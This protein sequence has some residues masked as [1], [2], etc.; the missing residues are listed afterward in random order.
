VIGCAVEDS[1]R[2]HGRVDVPR[3]VIHL[4]RDNASPA[5][6][7]GRHA[8]IKVRGYNETTGKHYS[9]RIPRALPA[10]NQFLTKV[11]MFQCAECKLYVSWEFGAAVGLPDYKRPP[12]LG[13]TFR[14]ALSLG[15][16]LEERDRY[17]LDEHL[18]EC[19]DNCW[20]E[21]VEQE[22]A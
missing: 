12:D 2:R 8:T 18:R 5:D 21:L 6:Y 19:C 3:K 15:S 20:A 16:T 17:R 11:E 13:K 14:T 10:R 22:A 1:H 7:R 4:N 9:W